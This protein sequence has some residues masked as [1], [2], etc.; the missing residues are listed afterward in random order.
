MNTFNAE[1]SA[2]REGSRDERL[3]RG[4]D[5]YKSALGGA[6]GC[7]LEAMAR[8]PGR[9]AVR[10]ALYDSQPYDLHVPAM[11]VSRLAITLTASR[12]SGSIEGDR[13]RRF[14]TSRHALFLTPAGAAAH[15]RKDSASRHLGIYF[16]AEAM[17]PDSGDTPK[18]RSDTPLLNATVPGLR[19]IANE[20]A[21]EM[22]A[23][24]LFATEAVDS[25][26]RLLLVRVAR[27]QNRTMVKVPALSLQQLA[28]LR[29]FALANLADRILVADLARVA[30]LSPHSFAH[31]FTESVGMPPHRFVVQLRLKRAVD[32]L[33]HSRRSLAEIAVECGFSS[34]QHMTNTMRRSLGVTPA[35]Y[36]VL[37]A[38]ADT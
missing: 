38:P 29:D 17:A 27:V 4:A 22:G 33:Q 34:Q 7:E 21:I 23:P 16:D 12:V 9:P 32:L 30:G 19:N 15:W 1:A 31:A 2:L 25:L 35:R 10:V 20:L 37:Q 28:R 5:A 36:R 11:Q 6:G 14:D 18:L 13:A 3:V 26:V 24:D 8:G